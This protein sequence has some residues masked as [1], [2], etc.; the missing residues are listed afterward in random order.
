[1]SPPT[2]FLVG[3]GPGNAGLLTLRALECLKQAEVVIH[4]KLVPAAIVDFAPP[5]AERI[6]V[7]ELGGDHT[8]R[9]EPVQRM[10]IARAR[11]GK[12]VVR[13]KG[14]DPM[15]FG[16][17]AEE[18]Q[19]LRNAGISYEIVPGV[20]AA[21]G[22]AYAGIPLTHRD[23]ASAVAIV[24][25]HEKPEKSDGTLDWATLARFPGTLVIYMGM[26]RLAEIVRALLEQGKPE[27]TPAAVIRWATLGEQ[28]TVA[29]TLG[30]LAQAVA[31][32][33]LG[34]PGIVII[35]SVVRLR[36]QLAWFEQRPLYGKRVLVTRP[37]QQAADL[38]RRLEQL[39]AVP[40]VLPTVEICE[41]ADWQPVDDAL[42]QLSSFHWLV[43]T[44]ANGVHAF[45]K[46]LKH[47]GR[48]LR[49]LGSLKLAAIGPQTAQALAE[50]HLHVD[51]L[52]DKYQSEYLAAEL[53]KHVRPGERLLLARADKGRE[54]LRDTLSAICAV[55]QVAVYSQVDAARPDPDIMARLR[56][57]EVDF[58]TLTSSNIAK[59]FCKILDAETR[60]QIESGRTRL[61]SISGVTS[62]EIQAQGLPVAGQAR[63]ATSEGILG[64]LIELALRA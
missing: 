8:E 53:T 33:K 14:G 18:A 12:R 32:A 2:V 19:A 31:E 26:L 27:E 43:F 9:Q 50:Y 38:V 39:A 36:S 23:H 3:A 48:D 60:R 22:A 16:R 6:S 10:M 44:S 28:Q 51:L 34:P 29:A 5:T 15:L 45:L 63:Q 62:A 20:T 24:T 55:Q 42:A 4:D 58:V 59:A 47:S 40:L 7:A 25:G 49:A 11:E 57:G 37:R 46:R 52:P 41:P 56:S 13:L 61:V 1:M 21:L 30:S 64:A 35:G 54:L 17:G